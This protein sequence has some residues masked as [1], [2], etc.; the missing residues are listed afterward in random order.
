[1]KTFRES[2]E[3]YADLSFGAISSIGPNGAIVHYNAEEDTAATL[4]A[5]EVYLLDSGGQY[6]DG[7]TDTTRTVHFGTPT[8]HEKEMYTRVLK[9]C[10]ELERV[11]WPEGVGISG[12]ELD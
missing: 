11:I 1:M 2:K 9:G 12:R 3:D 6:Q 5:N 4:N 8:E 7:T 10:L